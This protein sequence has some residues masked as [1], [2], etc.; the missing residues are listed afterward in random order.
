MVETRDEIARMNETDRLRYTPMGGFWVSLNRPTVKKMITYIYN[1]K[2]LMHFL[3]YC[4]SPDEIFYQ[5]FVKNC[6]FID[7][8]ELLSSEI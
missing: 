8:S 1:E 2:P 7:D 5:T 6:T 4:L 3:K